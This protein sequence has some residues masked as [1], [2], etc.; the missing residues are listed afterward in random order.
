MIIK[1]FKT[2]TEANKFL[3]EIAK[4]RPNRKVAIRRIKGTWNVFV[5]ASNQ[6]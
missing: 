2:L 4:K 6:K 1:Q 3:L 5:L